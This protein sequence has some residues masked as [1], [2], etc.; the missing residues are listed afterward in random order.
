MTRQRNK[1]EQG[2][3]HQG[4]EKGKK[5]WPVHKLPT[6]T[7]SQK[8]KRSHQFSCLGS[9]VWVAAIKL[10]VHTYRH[11]YLTITAPVRVYAPPISTVAAAN[12]TALS[13]CKLE[14]PAWKVA[15]STH[16]VRQRVGGKSRPSRWLATFVRT[17]AVLSESDGCHVSC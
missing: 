2:Q 9:L 4:R 7:P 10:L 8:G 6:A 15:S 16:L 3:A 5:R 17:R 14:G 1:F 11:P 13:G 12:E